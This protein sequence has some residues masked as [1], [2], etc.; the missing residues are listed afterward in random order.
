M[1]ITDT[2]YPVQA[3]QWQIFTLEASALWGAEPVVWYVYIFSI[4]EN[5]HW[6]FLFLFSTFAALRLNLPRGTSDR[7]WWLGK[8]KKYMCVSGYP[9]YPNFSQRP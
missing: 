4:N 7:I 3:V 2:T 5:V 9:T 8:K 6:W 1:S